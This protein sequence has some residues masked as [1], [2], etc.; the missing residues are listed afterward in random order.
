MYVEIQSV[1]HLLSKNQQEFLML[2]E[3][4]KFGLIS[5]ETEVSSWSLRIL[6]DLF[7]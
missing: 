3:I 4:L 6:N 7:N 5:N 2:L 1:K